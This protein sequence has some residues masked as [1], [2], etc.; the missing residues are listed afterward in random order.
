MK[1]Y[2]EIYCG[3]G[4]GKTTACVGLTVR[5][6]G[7]DIPVIFAQFLKNDSSGEINVLKKLDGVQLFHS[8]VFYGFYKD[9]N[10][11]QREESKK[12][13][14]ELLR[15][16]YEEATLQAKRVPSESYIGAVLILDEI[17]G[18]YQL[19][20]I[21][22]EELITMLKNKPGNLEIVLSGREAPQELCELADYIS[23][24]DCLAHPYDHQV[25]ARL[26]IE[27]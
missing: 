3:D 19:N 23:K 16:A 8:N 5:A 6:T 20:Q 14:I 27:R 12:A 24:I 9:M 17:L 10:S 1:G 21:D 2:I 18:A 25:G 4:K 7:N 15:R 26:G 22:Q 11:N 13:N